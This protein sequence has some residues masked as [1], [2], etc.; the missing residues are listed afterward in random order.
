MAHETSE[1]LIQTAGRILVQC[2]D[3]KPSETLLVVS[4]GTR[5]EICAAL[6]RAGQDLAAESILIEMSPRQRSGE[7]PPNLVTSAMSQANVV[8]CPT[9]HSLTHTMAK[10]A[11]AAA[12]ARIATMP[13]ITLDMFENGPIT[14][15]YTQVQRLTNI[16]T[17]ILTKGN[18][19]RVEKDGSVFE[20]SIRGRT[21]IPSTGIYREPGQSGNLPSGEAYIA[22][23]EGSGQG[24]LVI[25]GSMV[26]LGLLSDPLKLTVKDGLLVSAEGD[27]ADEWL[28]QLGSSKEARNVAELGV[29]TNP[30]A[31][32]TGVI[33]EDEK[34][35]GTI[36]VAFGSNATFGGTVQAGVHM[37]G[38]IKK[39]TVYV[40]GQLIMKE[41][42]PVVSG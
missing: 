30:K 23:V 20:C 36:H 33:L 7:E 28:Q 1:K 8:V 9:L 6:V 10:K 14:A 11:A 15:D 2:L 13:G 31:R 26:G 42:E 39:P 41:G 29:G 22:P 19:V 12:G 5:P 17:E 38:V 40:D 37:D 32:L 16:I 25:D 3:V 35:Y 27:R 18:H 24:E 34:A 21:G 4:D